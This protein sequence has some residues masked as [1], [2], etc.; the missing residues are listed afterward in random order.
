MNNM[1]S[2]GWVASSIDPVTLEPMVW[3]CLKLDNPRVI[4]GDY[5]LSAEQLNNPRKHRNSL[6]KVGYAL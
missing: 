3:N 1:Q 4:F 6:P 2:G 5:I